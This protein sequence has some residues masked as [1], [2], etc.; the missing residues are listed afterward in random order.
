MK[1]R[2]FLLAL[3]VAGAATPA[4]AAK[5]SF[6][7]FSR[8]AARRPLLI[9]G[10]GIMLEMNTALAAAFSNL[11]RDIDVVIDAGG[12]VSALIALKRGSIDVAAMSRDLR[13]TEDEKGLRNYLVARTGVDI[14]VSNASPITSLTSTQ[15]REILVGELDNWIQAGGP[16]APIHVFTGAPS[17]RNIEDVVLTTGEITP[18]G[19]MFKTGMEASKAVAADPHAIG[20]VLHEEKHDHASIRYLPIDGVSGSDTTMLSNRYPFTTSLYFAVMHDDPQSPAR[21]WIDFARSD[22]GQKIISGTRFIAT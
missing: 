6:W 20:F 7:P 1:R 19:T 5:L 14:V 12:S 10:S 8:R 15:V 16:E 9:A 18:T 22:A 4:Y 3:G 17:H 11:Y 2:A 21:L 13:E